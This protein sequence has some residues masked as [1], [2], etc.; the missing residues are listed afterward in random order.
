MKSNAIIVLISPSQH[1]GFLMYNMYMA[2]VQSRKKSS[3]VI[4][5]FELH[6]RSRF[7]HGTSAVT[8]TKLMLRSS[9]SDETMQNVLA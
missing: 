1:S 4:R 5:F 7:S 2:Y 9:G 8:Y 6:W 3:Y